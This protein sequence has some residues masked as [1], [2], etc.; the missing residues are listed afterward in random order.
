MRLG[1]Y[2]SKTSLC[3]RDGGEAYPSRCREG[4]PTQWQSGLE[5]DAA[6]GATCCCCKRRISAVLYTGTAPGT[7]TGQIFIIPLESR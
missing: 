1:C 6:T 5:L 4:H 2:V 7:G 3:D